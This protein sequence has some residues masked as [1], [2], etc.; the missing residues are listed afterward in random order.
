MKEAKPKLTKNDKEYWINKAKK[1]KRLPL[2]LREPCGYLDWCLYEGCAD[3]TRPVSTL[4]KDGAKQEKERIKKWFLSRA[5]NVPT[6][7]E[8]L[9][10]ISNGN[11]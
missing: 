6:Y 4:V 8:V 10:E 1:D 2:S 11:K 5:R 3:T 9:K 7:E